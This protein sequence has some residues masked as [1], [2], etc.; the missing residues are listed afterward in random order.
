[1]ISIVRRSV[2]FIL[3]GAA[4]FAKPTINST[5]GIVSAA[6]YVPAGFPNSGVAQGSIFTLFG[7]GL[8][9]PAL[10]QVTKF[11][12]PKSLAGTS[13]KITVGGTSVDAIMLWTVASQVAAIL[14]SSAPTG[15]A[16]LVLTYNGSASDPIPFQVVTSSFGAFTLNSGGSGTAVIT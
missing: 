2:L 3:L 4:A 9:P 13:I 12:L 8:G 1:M 16:Q 11:P 10:T 5:P 15:S 7:S 14:P 6:T